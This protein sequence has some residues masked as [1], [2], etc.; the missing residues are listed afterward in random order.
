M[1]VYFGFVNLITWIQKG[2]EALVAISLAPAFSVH[3]N[4][5]KDT[6]Y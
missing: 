2:S 4:K 6:E 3:C 1:R 5:K